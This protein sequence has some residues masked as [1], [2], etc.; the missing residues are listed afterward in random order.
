[1]KKNKLI[2]R[3]LIIIAAC[4]AVCSVP[5]AANAWQTNRSA[6][7]KSYGRYVYQQNGE[8]K[9]VLDAS[10]LFY[11]ADEIDL[12]EETYKKETVKALKEM[13]TYFIQNNSTTHDPDESNLDPDNAD[14][15][16]FS[17]IIEGIL[18]SQ[19]IPVEKTY[20]GTLP[21][22]NEVTGN[23]TA[24]IEGSL[25]LGAA[26]WVDGELII[27]NGADNKSYY[28]AGYTAGL[29]EE[30]NGVSISYI[31]HQH[32][33]DN[34]SGGGCFVVPVTHRHKEDCYKKVSSSEY[35]CYIVE[36]HDTTDGDYEG[37]DY[38]IYTMSC[39]M[40]IHGTNSSHT[41]EIAVCG[42]ENVIEGYALGCGKNE[43]SIESATII[44]E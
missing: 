25:S 24:A 7:L 1:M 32:T 22:G 9:V 10:D 27:G 42:K 26:A 28:A 38:K 41:H 40:V 4:M 20:S 34:V 30:L 19:S 17:S 5:I 44:F 36:W 33:G 2:K 14:I 37:H 39:G 12:L 18:D 31:Y 23:I 29:N 16:S 35:G 13:N 6:N 15:L 11:L 3:S 8:Q 21:D 43:S